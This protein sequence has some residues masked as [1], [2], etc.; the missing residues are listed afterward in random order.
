MPIYEYKAY[1]PG[2]AT[3]SG[4]VDADTERDARNK[5]RRDRLLVHT[6]SVA[7]GRG[8]KRKKMDKS[9]RK[10][11]G[12]L[13]RALDARAARQGPTAKEDEIICGITRQL[14]TLLGSGIPLTESL[15]AIVDQAEKRNVETMF[16][17]VREDIQTGVNLADALARHP[18][19]FSE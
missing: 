6:I 19:W 14:A 5:L 7:R 11:E 17:Q 12:M 15:S 4:I 9:S 1:A 16:R 13:T 10:S 3:K 8:A 18:R 2:G